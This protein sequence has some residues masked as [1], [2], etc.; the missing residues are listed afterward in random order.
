MSRDLAKAPFLIPGQLRGI[1]YTDLDGTLLDFD[2]FLPSPSAI[3]TVKELVEVGVMTVPVTSKT[4]SEVEQLAAILPLA[5]IAAAEGGAVLHLAGGDPRLLGPPR[6][7]LIAILRTLQAEGWPVRG[8][9]EMGAGEVAT[10]TGLSAAASERALQRLASE[11]F[12]FV[13]TPGEGV[14]ALERRVRELGGNLVRGG[15]LWHLLGAGVDKGTAIDE[16]KA[17][18][19]MTASVPAAAV[20]DA[21]NDLE[22]M[23]KVEHRFLL[24]TTVPE[25]DIPCAVERIAERGPA[26]FVEAMLRFRMSLKGS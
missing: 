26:G 5:P 23:C 7:E 22:M 6:S 20:G 11:P 4:L 15:R 18:M 9:S 1:V 21:W 25:A 3:A 12:T 2:T 17:C 19:P 10:I 24:G 16:V 8:L 14:A 13:S